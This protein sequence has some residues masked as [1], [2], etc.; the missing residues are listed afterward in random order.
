MK[1]IKFNLLAIIGMM[2][3]VGT[4]AFTAPM[5]NLAEP[6]WYAV[7]NNFDLSTNPSSSEPNGT[8]CSTEFP[9]EIHCS[10]EYEMLDENATQPSNLTELD[11]A[12]SNNEIRVT[13]RAYQIED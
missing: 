3:A 10:V 8:T 6:Q 11:L 12:V 2:V 1:Q 4:V 7:T 9:P 5:K 13:N